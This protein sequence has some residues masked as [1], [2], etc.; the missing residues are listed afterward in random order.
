VN[1]PAGAGT[2]SKGF[3]GENPDMRGPRRGRVAMRSLGTLAVARER[4]A[5]AGPA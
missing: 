5:R 1:L 2:R 3:G 4:G